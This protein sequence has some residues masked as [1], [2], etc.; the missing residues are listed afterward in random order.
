[1]APHPQEASL[2][3]QE[4]TSL[5]DLVRQSR[6][7]ADSCVS[8]NDLGQVKARYVGKK[9]VLVSLG[10]TM[11]ALPPEERKTRGQ[12]LNAARDAIEEIFTARQS[13]LEEQEERHAL[14]KQAT[15]V[16]LPS[17]EEG[18][19]GL[20]PV[21][22]VIRELRA[23]FAEHGF[24]FADG[25]EIED[26][27]HNFTA[28]NMP[29]D[30]P[31]RQMQD[32]FYIANK[33]G[34][35]GELLLRT[36]TSSVQIRELTGKNPPLRV[37]SAGRVYRSDYDA[38]H[39]PMFHQIEGVYIDKDVHMGH[40]KYLL[41][42]A[43]VRFFRTDALKLRF[44][45]SFFPFT[46]PSAEVDVSCAR[47]KEG[48]FIGE[49]ADWMEILGCGMI[50]PNVLKNLGIDPEAYRGFAFGVGVERLAML[51]YGAADL[52]AFFN[53]DIRWLRHYGTSPA[54]I[55]AAAG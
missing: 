31:A 19:S 54:E 35:P 53:A 43:L 7:D 34:A 46:E 29:P 21:T 48:V 49:G 14:I 25:P 41:R 20:H 22:V 8:L 11:G 13:A 27:H 37:I 12:E 28:L 2:T 39:T 47:T 5:D 23:I 3:T 52:R 50:H 9:S 38:T 15:D 24:Y 45:P 10:K 55:C 33:N 44:R 16:T 4:L 36:H 30:H 26:D 1:M 17:N 6:L 51:K 32:T 40:V 42:S 18:A